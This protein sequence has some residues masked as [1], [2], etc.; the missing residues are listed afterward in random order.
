MEGL[1]GM[2]GLQ[3]PLYLLTFHATLFHYVTQLKPSACSI[4][5]FVFFVLPSKVRVAGLKLLLSVIWSRN[6]TFPCDSDHPGSILT[7]LYLL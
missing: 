5:L 4:F 2:T 3:R 7:R 1:E 6:A